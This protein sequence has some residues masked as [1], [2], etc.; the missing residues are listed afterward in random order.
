MASNRPIDKT[1]I[2]ATLRRPNLSPNPFDPRMPSPSTTLI[3]LL[4]AGAA[5]TAASPSRPLSP[6][7]VAAVTALSS[8][9]RERSTAEGEGG[10][11]G[12]GAESADHG[13][14]PVQVESVRFLSAT[15]PRLLHL[16]G[17]PRPFA[18]L[19]LSMFAAAVNPSDGGTEDGGRE[20]KLNLTE[21]ARERLTAAVKACEGGPFL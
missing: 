12:G 15:I 20:G 9:A 4:I 21:S 3:F 2:D 13:W 8:A 10:G 14:I 6:L 19:C 16:H 11:G 7:A 1:I 5:G 18:G 17:D